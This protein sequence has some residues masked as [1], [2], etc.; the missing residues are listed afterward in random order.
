MAKCEV[1]RKPKGLDTPTTTCW[2]RYDGQLGYG[3]ESSRAAG[4][5][6]GPLDSPCHHCGVLREGYHHCGCDFEQCP[7]CGEQ[8]LYCRCER[9]YLVGEG[10]PRTA[11][12][13]LICAAVSG[14]WR[15]APSPWHS[16]VDQETILAWA[17]SWCPL[18]SRGELLSAFG[19]LMAAPACFTQVLYP[20]GEHGVLDRPYYHCHYETNY[21]DELP[22]DIRLG[23]PHG[24]AED[25][26]ELWLELWN[27]HSAE[28]GDAWI[29]WGLCLA[30]S[31]YGPHA[32][33]P[34]L[35]PSCS[36]FEENGSECH[37]GLEFGGARTG[38]P[39]MSFLQDLRHDLTDAEW[40]HIGAKT[41]EALV[42]FK[43]ADPSL[44]WDPKWR[45]R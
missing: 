29:W 38:W 36:W 31:P 26:R 42:A 30:R 3:C 34:C 25:A 33:L 16:P 1:C 40:G 45:K 2:H 23:G 10:R 37:W 32:E 19:G 24:S 13:A 28:F 15:D 7:T 43:R 44:P 21:L 41:D 14:W 6:S 12:Q 18:A 4:V 8:T 17:R 11:R 39:D 20:T 27:R 9:Q 35:G 22:E 5:D